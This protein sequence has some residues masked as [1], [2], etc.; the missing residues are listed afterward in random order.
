MNVKILH[1]TV[2]FLLSTLLLA[3]SKSTKLQFLY[4]KKDTCTLKEMFSNGKPDIARAQYSRFGCEIPI[5]TKKFEKIYTSCA[6]SGINIYKE[7]SSNSCNFL[8]LNIGYTFVQSGNV[9]CKF[10]CQKK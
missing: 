2:F 1:A 3:E 4:I 5:E 6:L 10:V 8:K 9:S 7:N